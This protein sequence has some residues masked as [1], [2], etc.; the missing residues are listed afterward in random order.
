MRRIDAMNMRIPSAWKDEIYQNE[1]M[2]LD[3]KRE[4]RELEQSKPSLQLVKD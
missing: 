1:L 2:K 3:I 4:M